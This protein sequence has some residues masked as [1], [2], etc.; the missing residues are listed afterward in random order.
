M[1]HEES[2]VEDL[3]ESSESVYH[4]QVTEYQLERHSTRVRTEEQLV[5]WAKDEL[6]NGNKRENVKVMVNNAWDQLLTHWR[7]GL[8]QQVFLLMLEKNDRNERIKEYCVQH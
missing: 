1:E 8:K 4:R 2:L 5:M 7:V 6:E 3:L